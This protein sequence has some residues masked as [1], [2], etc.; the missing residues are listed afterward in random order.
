MGLQLYD[1]VERS[2]KPQLIRDLKTC[3]AKT[4][5]GESAIHVTIDLWAGDQ[6]SPVEEPIVIV[7]LHFVNDSWQIRR[8]IVAFRHLSNKN[9]STAVARELE[10]VLLSYGIFP[11]SIGY[12]LT[13]QAKETVA[14]NN[15]FCD[16]KI[17]CSSNRGEP[18]GDEIVSFLSDQMSE[19]ELPFSELQIGTRTTCVANTLQL[20]I[21]EALKNS[22]VVENLLM[23]VHNV[24]AFFRS[25][26]YWSEVG[27]MDTLKL[28]L[29]VYF[30]CFAFAKVE[31]CISEF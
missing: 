18:D 9:L 23:Q 15:L 21:K 25:S 19:T 6:S 3:L 4:K 14:G 17:M 27:E 30:T 10:G 16:Y 29:Q 12:V 1:E 2:I 13:N 8:P 20:V 31:V 5:D 7:Q 22:R 28:I 11:R 26:A 24:V